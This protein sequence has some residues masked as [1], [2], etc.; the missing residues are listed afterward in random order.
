M[1]HTLRLYSRILWWW[2]WEAITLCI[3]R[4]DN[5]TSTIKTG[6]IARC[7]R[8]SCLLSRNV[9]KAETPRTHTG[10]PQ[11]SQPARGKQDGGEER[12]GDT[13]SQCQVMSDQCDQVSIIIATKLTGRG[14]G[15][16]DQP[17]LSESRLV[18]S[19]LAGN[20]FNYKTKT[21]LKHI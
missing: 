8:L 19:R 5:I 13:S 3:W 6:H 2:W 21:C 7:C 11:L 12:R 20:V 10:S 16:P 9:I 4:S 17:Q 18:M 1:E 15:G 14:E